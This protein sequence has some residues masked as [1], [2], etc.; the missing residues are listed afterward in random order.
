MDLIEIETRK[1]TYFDFIYH[2]EHNMFNMIYCT[3]T[4]KCI[5]MERLA[6]KIFLQIK[7]LNQLI[8]WSDITNIEQLMMDSVEL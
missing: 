5:L 6:N 2:N 4:R 7:N 3:T 1:K 8:Y